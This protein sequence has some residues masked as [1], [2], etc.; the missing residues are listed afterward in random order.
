MENK[1]KRGRMATNRSLFDWMEAMVWALS[2]V[3]FVFTFLFHTN[4]VEG[5]SMLPTLVENDRLLITHV[6]YTPKAGDV[7][8]ISKES[9]RPYPVVKRIIAT[10]GQTVDID[11]SAGEVYVDGAKLDEDYVKCPTNLSYDVTFPLTVP[12]NCVFVMG[13]NRNESDDSRDSDLGCVDVRYI[14]GH[15]VA[16]FWPLN[17]IRVIE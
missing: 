15:A 11:F 9:F 5:R 3:I 12:E 10:E 1:Q 7:V 14:Q 8:I 6:G 4:T 2:A 13:D 17:R 16:C